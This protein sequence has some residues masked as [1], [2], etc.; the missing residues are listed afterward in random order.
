MIRSSRRS[1]SKYFEAFRAYSACI[2]AQNTSIRPLGGCVVADIADLA[3]D[4]AQW[5]LDLALAAR[6]PAPV[7][8]SLEECVDCDEPISQ[9]RRLAAPGCMRCT[10]CQDLNEKQGARHAR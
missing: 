8:V 1:S 6:K 2:A 3:N 7:R 10:D 4:R 9:A 5:H